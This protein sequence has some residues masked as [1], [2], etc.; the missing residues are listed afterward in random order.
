MKEIEFSTMNIT[1]SAGIGDTF[2]DA[3]TARHQVK[4]KPFY[5][6]WGEAWNQLVRFALN[7]RGADVSEVGTTWLG[8]LHAMDALRPFTPGETTLLGGEQC[9]P[10]AIWQAC[11]IGRNNL[12][13]AIPLVLDMRMVLYRR[14][15]LQK[16]GADEA[17]A[18][19]D[20]GQFSE[21]LKQIKVAGHPAPLGLATSQSDT[22]PIHD[23]ACWVWSAGGELRSDD[24][25]R[26]MLME[27]QGRAGMQAYFGLNEFLSP[28]MQ[29][30]TESEV[31]NAF[32]A[33]KTAVAILPERTYLE[34][35]LN[36]SNVSA[37]VV[38]NVGMAMLMQAPYIGGSALAIWRY[39]SDYQDSLKLIQYLTDM[40]IWQVLNKQHL[41]YTPAHLDA[42]KQAPL[43]SIPFYPAVQKTIRDGRSFHSGYRWSRVEARLVA[44]IEQMWGDLRANP[45]LNIEREVGQRFSSVCNRLEQTILASSSF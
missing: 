28:E 6:D 29:A 34:V 27:S 36:R 10:P 25:H 32:F 37:K 17:T 38:D 23:A 19:A 21:T 14:D 24:E 30:L 11:H 9:Y 2:F 41:P 13:L 4:V 18:F 12:M 35:V 3:F 1:P 8:G 44:V 5:M 22:R 15:W 43:A 20:P 40:E 45:E 16:A 33:G 31:F 26:M 39:S 7:S 42:L